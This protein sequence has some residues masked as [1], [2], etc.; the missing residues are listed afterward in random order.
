MEPKTNKIMEVS[1]P[2]NG[3]ILK[4]GSLVNKSP[5]LGEIGLGNVGNS[6]AEGSRK[7]DASS[8]AK[9]FTI[10]TLPPNMTKSKTF[11]NQSSGS[12]PIALTESANLIR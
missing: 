2:I 9:T 5:T 7:D 11:S 3:K 8:L 6:E 12:V 4:Q 10:S 1:T